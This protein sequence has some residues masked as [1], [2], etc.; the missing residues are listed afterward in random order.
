MNWTINQTVDL[1]RGY[2]PVIWPDALMV[3]GD[4][5]AHTWRVSVMDGGTPADLTSATI[6]GFFVREDGVTVAVAGSVS[7]NTASVTLAQNC[8]A[9]PGR[10]GGVLRMEVSGKTVTLS[11]VM[12]TVKRLTTDSVV[13]P[14]QAFYN[15]EALSML[16]SALQAQVTSLASGAPKG[17]YATVAD[18][19]SADPDHAHIY[20]VTADG[21]WYFWN[22]SAWASGGQYLAQPEHLRPVP[23]P[24][25]Y[26]MTGI[27]MS[28]YRAENGAYLSSVTPE[29]LFPVTSGVTYYCDVVNGSDGNDGL[30]MATAYKRPIKAMMNADCAEII[31]AA[32]WYDRE[33]V[34]STT[35]LTRNV[36]I[37]AAD[38]AQVYFYGGQSTD[39]HTPLVWT[40]HSG[41]TY[42]CTRSSVNG[43]WDLTDLLPG[44]D[45]RRLAQKNSVA[46]VE[47][48]AGGWYSD[49]S[50][51][52][53]R[54]LDGRV[55]DANVKV[56]I[57]VDTMVVR[58]AI[59]VYCENINFMFGRGVVVQTLDG[60]NRPNFY[61]QGCQFS[62]SNANNGLNV[63]GAART[64]LKHCEAKYNA[65][66][67]FNYHG[68]TGSPSVSGHALEIDC[69]GHHNGN[70]GLGINNGSTAHE[71]VKIIRIGGRYYAN[72]GPNIAD[73]NVSRALCV[74]TR[75]HNTTTV[76]GS[77]TD[78]YTGYRMFLIDCAAWGSENSVTA[79]GTAIAYLRD[80]LVLGALSGDVRLE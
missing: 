31:C 5:K 56:S 80:S 66:D 17:T 53:V 19:T 9:V 50:L 60:T 67:G 64:A 28:I 72:E 49:G 63:T 26:E 32:G 15:T 73:V 45:Y 27:P 24:P 43:V 70:T 77:K 58:G 25:G 23:I 79:S 10:L 33:Q 12:Y 39:G 59:S 76:T 3:S 65:A 34:P 18:L 44:G 71:S 54:L 40:L 29:G 48:E 38:G 16:Y 11:S 69:V 35:Y 75:A 21:N 74:G 46:E 13:D 41:T 1:S 57:G 62:C 6:T 30:T 68:Y 8:Y 36:K 20:V 51:V 47:A 61:A 22:G 4:D 55:P 78:F 14:G 52:Y 7:D 42:K 37:R 2:T